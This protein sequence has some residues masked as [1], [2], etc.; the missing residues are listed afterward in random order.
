MLIALSAHQQANTLTSRFFVE[1][2]SGGRERVVELINGQKSG[3]LDVRDIQNSPP[4]ATI[5][6]ELS[7]AS[8][9]SAPEVHKAG[10]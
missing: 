9:L 5:I 4:P 6:G 1:A 10:I 8:N 3:K 2:S 7:R